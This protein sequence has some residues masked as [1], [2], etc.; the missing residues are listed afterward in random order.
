LKLFI[1]NNDKR[2]T[3]KDQNLKTWTGNQIKNA[4]RRLYIMKNNEIYNLWSEFI[5][6]ARYTKYFDSDNLKD[7]KI[8]L[9]FQ[10][11]KKEF[12]KS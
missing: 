1:D 7:W 2:P 5:S 6:D 8:K 12:V 9:E 3:H 10:F 4:Q 11:I